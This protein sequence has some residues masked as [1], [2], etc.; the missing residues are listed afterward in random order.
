MD[1][2]YN[3]LG[4]LVQQLEAYDGNPDEQRVVIDI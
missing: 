2:N 3:L 1:F 4:K